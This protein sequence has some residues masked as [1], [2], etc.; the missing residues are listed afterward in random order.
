M[1][2]VTFLV[3][4]LSLL[5]NGATAHTRKPIFAHNSSKDAVWCKKDPFWYEKCVV[6]KFGVFNP[7]TPLKWVGKVSQ[8]KMSNKFETVRDTRNMSMNHD[9][10]TGVSLSGSV[11]KT[12]VKICAAPCGEGL[13]MTSYLVGNKTSLYG[14][15]AS[16]IKS[17]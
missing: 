6:V 12:C 10:E 7:K 14:N 8:N 9:S 1:G 5:F 15:Q 2:P 17:Y 16:Q 4:F 13:T 11:N 3:F